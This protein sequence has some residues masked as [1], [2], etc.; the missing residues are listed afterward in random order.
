MFESF[1]LYTSGLVALFLVVIATIVTWYFSKM[2]GSDEEVVLDIVQDRKKVTR[3]ELQQETGLSM[4]KLERIIQSLEQVMVEGEE[5]YY[6]GE[7]RRK[8]GEPRKESESS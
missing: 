1:N 8:W 5:V 2:E 6:T 7:G 4:E 3:E